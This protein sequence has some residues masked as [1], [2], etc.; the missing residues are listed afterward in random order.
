MRR[1]S[2]FAMLVAAV[3][4]T[5]H[6]VFAQETVATL[7]VRGDIL[8][9]GQWSVVDLKQQF[10]KEVQTVRFSPGADK[11]QQVGTGI[12]LVSL[13]QAAAP[14]IEKVPKHYDLTFLVILEAR[15]SYRV[16]FSLAELLP[17]CGHAQ[18]WLVWD[19][20]GKPLSGNEAPLRLVV[21]SDRG[22]DRYIY[23]IVGVNL[24]DGTKLATQLATGR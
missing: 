5:G 4:L 8:K 11:P 2:G 6:S 16:F 10:A 13:I 9:P 14:K 22:H 17:Q 19:V 20:D 1:L 18:V 23:G 7:A 3:L 15:D 12:P 24:V 21:L